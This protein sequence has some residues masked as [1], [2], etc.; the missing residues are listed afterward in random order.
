MN[1][2]DLIEAGKLQEAR[3]ALIDEVKSSPGDV[4]TRGL[5]F[6]VLAF[7]GEWDSAERHLDVIGAQDLKAETGVQVYKNLVSG[8]RERLEVSKRNR[9]PAF[10]PKICTITFASMKTPRI[11][12]RARLGL[13]KEGHRILSDSIETE[14]EH[15]RASPWA[16]EQ[17]SK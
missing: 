8:E 11:F 17:A 15:Y 3:K 7:C 13:R 9:R 5:L 12:P 2:K 16:A 6:Q 1:A 4:R 14:I 10:L